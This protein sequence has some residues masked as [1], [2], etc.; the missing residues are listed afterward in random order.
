MPWVVVAL[1][2]GLIAVAVGLT[3]VVVVRRRSPGSAPEMTGDQ[4]LT[5]GV[6]FT[7]TGVALG[8]TI[9]PA[10]LGIM[11]LGIVYMAMGAWMKR[12]EGHH[13]RGSTL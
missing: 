4:L 2:I 8:L 13:G 1:V 9:G 12:Q 7:G 5:L 11:A 10:M 3:A 6:I